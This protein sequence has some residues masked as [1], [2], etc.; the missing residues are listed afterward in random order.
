MR[1]DNDNIEQTLSKTA[2][3]KHMHDL[4]ALGE[5]LLT[6]AEDKLQQLPISDQLFDALMLAKKIHG[7][8]NQKNSYRR[9][10]QFIGKI[11]RSENTDVIKQQLANLRQ[12][13]QQK[14]LKQEPSQEQQALSTQAREWM[15]DLLEKKDR[16][17][18]FLSQFPNCDRQRISQLLRAAKGDKSNDAD[19]KGLNNKDSDKKTSAKQQRLLK[20]ITAI[21]ANTK[22]DGKEY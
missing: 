8:N 19:S 18:V 21:L 13:L 3:K 10:L 7:R 17:T 15:A 12:P 2:Q 1:E 9:Q 16:L 22:A 4:Q 11:M 20:E 14:S 5:S 6:L